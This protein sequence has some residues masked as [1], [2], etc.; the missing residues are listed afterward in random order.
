M[1]YDL[2]HTVYT[3]NVVSYSHNS[4]RFQFTVVETLCR[5]RSPEWLPTVV[6]NLPG[7]RGLHIG[8]L[9]GKLIGKQIGKQISDGFINYDNKQLIKRI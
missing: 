5:N 9:I 6:D 7:H 8:K 2:F 4:R 3:E 1:G